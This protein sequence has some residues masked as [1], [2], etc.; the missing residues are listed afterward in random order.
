LKNTYKI[1]DIESKVFEKISIRAKN[2]KGEFIEGTKEINIVKIKIH[3][4]RSIF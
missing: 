2:E 3:K 4:S 1:G